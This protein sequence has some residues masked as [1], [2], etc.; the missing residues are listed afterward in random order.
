MNDLLYIVITL[1]GLAVIVI[2]GN[3]L[4]TAVS[5][6]LL[7]MSANNTAE[8]NVTQS[9]I[10]AADDTLTNTFDSGF[11]IVFVLMVVSSMILGSLLPTNPIF[12]IPFIFVMVL[13][14]SITAI[15]SNLWDSFA[16]TS[17]MAPTVARYVFIPFVMNNMP[18]LIA[19]LGFMLSIVIYVSYKR[20]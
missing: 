16:T 3:M 8:H 6:T 13:L 10:N 19:G 11:L 1:L 14:V 4:L 18:W 15:V 17:A 12:F 5:P 9:T 20:G 2:L 7:L